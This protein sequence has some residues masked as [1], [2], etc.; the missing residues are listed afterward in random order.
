VRRVDGVAGIQDAAIILPT[1]VAPPGI[2]LT[3]EVA[4]PVAGT[5]GSG[6]HATDV[7]AGHCMKT[8]TQQTSIDLIH[9]NKP[10]EYS[11]AVK[12]VGFVVSGG[13][14]G[15]E[16]WEAHIVLSLILVQFEQ[17]FSITQ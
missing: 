15:Y 3:R 5:N 2:R 12:K 10:V 8:G 6:R 17:D 16:S 11:N 7:T 14:R 9:F 13:R 1:A 4:A